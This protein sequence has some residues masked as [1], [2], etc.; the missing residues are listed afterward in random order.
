MGIY[1]N[2]KGM[3]K[4]EWLKKNGVLLPQ[5][6]FWPPPKDTIPVCL[7]D[8]YGHHTAAGVAY[9]KSEYRTFTDPSDD[10]KRIWYLVPWEKLDGVLTMWELEE[11]EVWKDKVE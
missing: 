6:P 10:R 1:I 7:V 2:P 8:H 5:P 11:L 3:S 9:K 4:E